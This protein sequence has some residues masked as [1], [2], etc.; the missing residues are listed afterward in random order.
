[1]NDNTE[2][3]MQEPIKQERELDRLYDR[4]LLGTDN[5]SVMRR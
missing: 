4:G 1:M 3:N 2:E 5:P